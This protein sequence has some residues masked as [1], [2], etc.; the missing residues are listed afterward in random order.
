MFA[1]ENMRDICICSLSFMCVCVCV[2][3]GI[4]IL[5]KILVSLNVCGVCV[6][7]CLGVELISTHV[8]AYVPSIPSIRA[9]NDTNIH[10]YIHKFQT[11]ENQEYNMRSYMQESRLN[12]GPWSGSWTEASRYSHIHIHTQRIHTLVHLF[13]LHACE[14]LRVGLYMCPHTTAIHKRQILAYWVV[15]AYEKLL[16]VYIR[17]LMLLLYVNSSH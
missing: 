9:R 17:A 14:S 6:C 2:W 5:A 1:R 12:D 4:Q 7:V 8:H 11:L 10:T 13:V 3:Y 16:Q 15:Y